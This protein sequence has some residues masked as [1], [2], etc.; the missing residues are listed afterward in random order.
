MGKA[1]VREKIENLREKLNY[2][3]RRYFVD[4]VS[5]ISD[6]DYD[7][8]YKELEDLESQFP[9]FY[10]E[11]SPTCRVGNDMLT[12]FESRAHA[13]AMLSLSNTYSAGELRDFDI[14]LKNF[15]K[16]DSEIEYV[17]EPKIDGLGISLRYEN[18]RFVYA[19]TRGNGERGD[20]VSLNVRTI[21]S[22]PMQ[23][24][25]EAPEVFEVRGEIF[26][27]KAGFEKLN[28]QRALE[29]KELF[30]NPRNCAS[31]TLKLLDSNEVAKRP[32][33]AI[34]YAAGEL[35]EGPNSHNEFL[36]ELKGFG[37]KV[38]GSNYCCRG[39]EAVL[40]KVREIEVSRGSLPFEIDGAV[41]KVNDYSLQEKLGFTAKSPRWAIAYKY[42]AAKAITKVNAISV[43]VGRTGALTPVAELEPV[44]L[45]GST[46]SR[47]TLHNFDELARKDVRVGDYV[48]I[49][50]AGEIIPAVIQV[51]MEKRSDDCKVFPRPVNCPVC[52]N[53]VEDVIGEAVIRCVNIQ[54][55]SV[56]KTSLVHFASRDAMDIDTLGSAVVEVL[57]D[58]NFVNDPA[59][60][61]E[62]TI[63]LRMR[64]MVLEGFGAK[65]VE[66]LMKSIEESKKRPADRF[67]F[68]LG[69]RHVGAKVASQLLQEY[70]SIDVFL[71]S[72]CEENLVKFKSLVTDFLPT[73]LRF[74]LNF[75][76][77]LSGIVEL[78]GELLRLKSYRS[79]FAIMA[80]KAGLKNCLDSEESIRG[81]L[82]EL[83]PNAE[84]LYRKVRGIDTA[85]NSSLIN[86]FGNSD[87][88]KLL[89]R[90]RNNG[91]QFSLQKREVVESNFT[92]KTCVLTGTL[93]RMDRRAA[94]VL[95]EK[96][97][98]KV[99]SSVTTK[100][101][102]VIAGESAGTKLQEAQK[103]GVRVLTEDEFLE[104]IESNMESKKEEKGG[105][106]QLMLF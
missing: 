85:V 12:Q 75:I 100:T 91:L 8:M 4:A 30:A 104:M 3:N 70:G 26:M 67:L 56:L 94:K 29:G 92:G 101:D 31:G 43:Q 49:E 76:K 63:E 20:D 46:V 47:A 25:Q 88:R 36:N 38:S 50:K 60:L 11:N 99:T 55:P 7:Q 72:A 58:N 54:C 105:S 69:I 61:Y 1:S 34:F 62:F 24:P 23:L 81:A 37:F 87:N 98:S 27:P 84:L 95:L 16:D 40:E 57:V 77:E 96:N 74:K 6:F 59:D 53:L 93:K 68:G 79:S 19:L 65:S 9:E 39:I 22:V 45:S 52:G 80:K 73:E 86:F 66:K 13:V 15:L 41:I 103:L 10:D 28:E 18:G 2:Y 33:E 42:E 78:I 89:E 48:E 32:L 5:E 97:G 106:E 21:R 35:S 82:E 44:F 14:R 83:L 17:V 102:Y 71:S 64:L 51:I 90:L